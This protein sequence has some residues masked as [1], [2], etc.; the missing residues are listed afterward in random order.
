MTDL[1]ALREAITQEFSAAALWF[2]HGAESA[3]DEAHWLVC[4]VAGLPFSTD[5]S[6]IADNTVTAEQLEQ[7]QVLAQRR[8]SEQTPLAYLL[9][10][11]WFAGHPWFIDENVL[12]PRSPFA[13]L[14]AGRF[15]PWF[16]AY[17]P[18]TILDMCTGS[19]CIGIATAL[20][21]PRSVVHISDISPA[22]L[23]IAQRNVVRHGVGDRV[24]V[25]ES[26]LFANIEG[27]FDLIV[28]NP[29]YV[30][31]LE[32]DQLPVEYHREPALGLLAGGDGLS[33]VLPMLEQAAGYLNDT[34]WLIVE[35]GN[36]AELLADC[37]PKIPFDWLEFEYGGDGVFAL[38]KAQLLALSK[39]L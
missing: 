11:A 10:E 38:S 33:L 31:Q 7:I 12:V 9:G 29:P 16:V 1:F 15:E 34:G 17:E 8:I 30:S 20:E 23:A 36:S 3:A 13:E 19:G 4:H 25:I 6:M 21:F 39:P 5:I 35:V 32:Y 27:R 2:G 28:S 22:A 26:D 37:Y 14:I 24:Q 18:G